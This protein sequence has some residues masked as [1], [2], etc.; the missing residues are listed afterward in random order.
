MAIPVQERWIDEMK[1]CVPSETAA[2]QTI[3]RLHIS[4]NHEKTEN[5]KDNIHWSDIGPPEMA[6]ENIG[7]CEKIDRIRE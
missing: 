3:T 5:A 1:K 7:K 6:K 2:A 4:C